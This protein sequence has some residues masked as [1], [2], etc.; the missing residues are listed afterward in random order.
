MLRTADRYHGNGLCEKL[1]HSS[2]L[3]LLLLTELFFTPY[4]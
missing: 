1:R 3:L 2:E 4:L